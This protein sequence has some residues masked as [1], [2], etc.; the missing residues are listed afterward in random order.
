M[1]KISKEIIMNE[2][3]KIRDIALKYCNGNGID[4]GCGDEKICEEAIG[5]DSGLDFLYGPNKDNR[6]LSCVNIR[7]EIYDLKMFDDKSLDYVYTSHFLE[8]L[9]DPITMINDIERVLRP[10]GYFIVYLPDRL[11][12]TEK[13]LEHHYMWTAREFSNIIPGNFEIVEMIE[14][15]YDYSFFIVA[16]KII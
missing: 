12:Y 8:H 11:L 4:L 13:N 3:T 5:I 6:N 9:P 16:R 10:G 1:A 7:K 15:Y 14:K 2:T